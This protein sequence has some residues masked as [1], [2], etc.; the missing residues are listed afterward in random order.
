MQRNC[1]PDQQPKEGKVG[2]EKG[3]PIVSCTAWGYWGE[4]IQELQAIIEDCKDWKRGVKAVGLLKWGEVM[5]PSSFW[6]YY[7]GSN[8]SH[9]AYKDHVPLNY[10]KLTIWHTWL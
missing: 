10:E 4:S 1:S 5:D 2:E 9:R 6:R 7:T 8:R 3:S